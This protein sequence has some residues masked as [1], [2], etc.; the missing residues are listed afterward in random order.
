MLHPGHY[1]NSIYGEEAVRDSLEHIK[2]HPHE[3]WTVKVA[4][5]AANLQT[6]QDHWESSKRL[7]YALGRPAYT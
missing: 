5:R 7:F 6:Q 2:K 3:I 1:D 4:A